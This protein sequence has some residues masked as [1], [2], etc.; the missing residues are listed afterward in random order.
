MEGEAA[1]AGDSV[2][3]VV[4]EDSAADRAAAAEPQG[5]GNV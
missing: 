1:S 4:L 5:V 2:E 3:A